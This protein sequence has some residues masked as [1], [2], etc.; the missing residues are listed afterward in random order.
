M[1]Q[2]FAILFPPVVFLSFVSPAFGFA[3]AFQIGP[4]RLP[5][6]TVGVS[7]AQQL[8]T[9]PSGNSPIVNTSG[10]IPP[11]MGIQVTSAGFGA[12]RVLTL[13]GTPTLAATYIF[14]L[15]E[16]G[17]RFEIT[18]RGTL[19]IGPP[20]VDSVTPSSGTGSSQTFDVTVSHGAGVSAI[21]QVYVII[22]DQLSGVRACYFSYI[23]STGG[24]WLMN[25]AGPRGWVHPHYRPARP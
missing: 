24:F 18:I 19:G 17:Q 5:D 15:D 12:I 2:A 16:S 10:V 13:V 21:K 4:T 6:G 25:D 14:S 1:K 9:L 20:A 23:R 7:Y 22:N 3:G 8:T 11:G